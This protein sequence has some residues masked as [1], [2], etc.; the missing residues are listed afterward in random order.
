MSSTKLKREHYRISK[1]DLNEFNLVLGRIGIRLDQLDAIGQVPDFKG[2]RL[3]NIGAPT[4]GDDALT[5]ESFGFNPSSTGGLEI[6]NDELRVK[7]RT[8]YGINRDV[9][10]LALKKQ[11]HV[12]D[13]AAVS[14]LSVAD[15]S[16]HMDRTAFNTALGTLVTE[17]NAIKTKLNSLLVSL[18]TA[19]VLKSS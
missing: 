3:T 12:V 15:G 6:V 10:G 8:D 4:Q 11:N 13:A 16:D 14:S 5:S 9:N 1:L 7:V 18:E 2:K 19:E 17:I